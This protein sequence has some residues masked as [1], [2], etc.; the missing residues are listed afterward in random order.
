MKVTL[1]PDPGVLIEGLRDTGY[2][3]NTA[4]ADVIDNSV[5]A[6]ASLVDV[7]V[8]LN[9][10]AS[11]SIIIT[12]DGIGMDKEE[13]LDGM[14]YGSK[15]RD[16]DPKR[17]GKFGL[18][19]KTASTA[20]CRRLS[21]ISRK[22]INAPFIMATWDLDQVVKDG[23]WHL[24]VSENEQDIPKM[25]MNILSN[26]TNNTGHGTLVTWEKI[27]RLELGKQRPKVALTNL[28]NRFEEHATMVYHRF[29]DT[30][31]ERARN[32]TMKLNGK[33][34]EPWDPFCTNEPQ[35][36]ML[37][38]KVK[39]VTVIGD[40]DSN[41]SATFCLKAYAIPQKDTFSSITAKKKA[42]ITNKNMGFYVYRENRMIAAADWLGLRD[43]DP[44]DSLSRIDFSFDHNLDAAFYID[45]KK[46]RIL[47]NSDLGEWL[48]KWV[49]PF[50]KFA[51]ERY[52]KGDQN[53]IDQSS[54]QVHQ[55]S[56]NN[57]QD[58]ETQSVNSKVTL[59]GTFNPETHEQDVEVTNP[60]TST[61]VRYTIRIPDDD[62]PGVTVFPQN[63]LVDGVLWAPTIKDGHH[64]V[65]INTQHPFY[66]KVYVPNFRENVVMQGLDA[67]LW[68][69][70]ESELSVMNQDV[71][72]TIDDLKNNVSRV[73][74][75]L[76]NDLPDPVV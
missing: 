21:V 48:N 62:T 65:I 28:I 68:A 76:V 59:S 46:S 36:K 15:N 50:V 73:L 70:A 7:R 57:I 47:L 18:G 66:H 5:D 19:L 11:P 6:Q 27:D 72:D 22:D 20:F 10:D 14:Q 52:R 31:D 33:L 29:L 13:L 16:K 40:D 61:P 23:A 17:L 55:P 60:N 4:L 67:L 53:K 54:K 71:K 39:A 56:D 44:H 30:D 34:L 37:G 25:Y 24:L 35:T 8:L 1:I 42:R 41:N 63:G 38:E 32:I 26:I 9:Q 75:K 2:D 45:V 49:T 12:D 51:N 43:N 74:K 58:K 69:L 64:A 3:F